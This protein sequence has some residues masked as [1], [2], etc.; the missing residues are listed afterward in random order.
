MPSGTRRVRGSTRTDQEVPLLLFQLE[1]LLVV[2]PTHIKI[3]PHV[4]IIQHRMQPQEKT[5]ASAASSAFAGDAGGELAP[6][7]ALSL[8]NLRSSMAA[9][10]DFSAKRRSRS[11]TAAPTV[12]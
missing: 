2:H 11:A 5:F 1:N 12:M 10:S 8:A 7:P 3:Q 6:P 9:T 4:T